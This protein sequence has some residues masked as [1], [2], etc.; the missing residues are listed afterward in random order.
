M[1]VSSKLRL[2]QKTRPLQIFFQIFFF[3]KGSSSSSRVVKF[4]ILITPKVTKP[5]PSN[6]FEVLSTMVGRPLQSDILDTIIF[7]HKKKFMKV[8][9]G[10]VAKND[11]F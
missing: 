1:L 5:G 2:G 9:L 11:V 8:R 6:F 10:R 7:L 4:E 3:T